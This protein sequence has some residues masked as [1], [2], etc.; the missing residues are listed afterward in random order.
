LAKTDLIVRLIGDTSSLN[1][2]LR[3]ATS[4]LNSFKRTIGTV[5]GSLG[6]AFGGAVVLR[7]IG[8]MIGKIADFEEQMDK[9]AA[10]SRASSKQVQELT[11]NALD[12]G[13]KSKF[14]ATQIA[15]MSE[16][17]ARLG[18]SARQIINTTEAVRK[19][20][21]AAGE[22]LAPSA[23]IMAGTLKSF[24]LETTESERVANVMAEAFSTT[25]LNLEKFGAGMANVG[26]IAQT[27]GRSLEF[28][29]AALG[30]LVDRNIDA[31]KAGTDLR[32]I[33]IELA[34]KGLTLEEAM[35]KIR[36][37]TDKVSTAVALFG[38]RSAASA[39]IL[40]NNE[41]KVN[42]LADSYADLNTELDNMVGIM[43]DNLNTDLKLMTSAID[44]V[45]QKGSALNDIFRGTIQL[46]TAMVGGD[47]KGGFFDVGTLGAEE[48][49]DRVQKLLFQLD[50]TNQKFKDGVIDLATYD[51]QV[52]KINNTLQLA[53]K[54]LVSL[55][56]LDEPFL[57]SGPSLRGFADAVEIPIG[58]IEEV[59]NQLKEAQENAKA[60]FNIS[61]LA[62]YNAEIASLKIK[63]EEL[64][65]IG[66][67]AATNI[68]IPDAIA[69]QEISAP[70]VTPVAIDTSQ[71]TGLESVREALS[72][73]RLLMQGEQQGL[74]D[75]MT[76]WNENVQMVIYG[77]SNALGDGFQAI[78][79][80][81]ASGTDPLES[82]GQAI[83][84]TFASL[85]SQL[86]TS[87][88]ASG[89]AMLVAELALSNP[90]TS[91]AGLIAAGAAL[92]L[93]GGAIGG[94][95]SGAM[96]GVDGG[97]ASAA[98]S[99]GGQ[100]A[101][102]NVGLGFENNREPQTVNI[103]GRIRGQDIVFV[104]EKANRD[105]GIR[106]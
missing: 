65:A 36:S 38:V 25:S 15:G 1:S 92:S 57:G 3:K 94:F 66:L 98:G 96:G 39:I 78:G 72:N 46:I 8:S 35:A 52:E 74:L 11:Q 59:S 105:L 85:M 100:A 93:L 37:S 54:R 23:A 58:L 24:N 32:K 16:T 28:T 67:S 60:A 19:L 97:G 22:E 95:A 79:A 68:P 70:L 31:S 27:T 42:S 48:L 45:I 64:N 43:E 18:F 102:G 104:Q 49:T 84:K 101:F 5:A 55:K 9:V 10:V 76:G 80:A 75:D 29:S 63:L 53:E 103:V 56:E 21:T 106:G 6:L 91:G 99:G 87:M 81:I 44:G 20:A 88:I 51:K 33:F 50:Q 47:V 89:V 4:G 82:A 30:T 17:L 62:G 41:D 14:T 26:A 73:E 71:L 69:R 40:S 13:A 34:N 77:V 86:G 7:G 90:F 2:N 12:L 61:Q 83:L